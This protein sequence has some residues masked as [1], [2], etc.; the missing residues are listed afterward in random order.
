[1]K[2]IF[3]LSVL[4]YFGVSNLIFSQEDS[5]DGMIQTKTQKEEEKRGF[6]KNYLE[7]QFYIGL[8]YNYLISDATKVVQHNFSRG[9]HTGFLRDIPM[10][11]RRNIGMALGLGYSYDLI[12]S[13]I[14]SLS[15]NRIIEYHIANNL[16][17]WN[18]NKNYF[19]T[20]TIELPIEF[21]WRTSTDKSHKFWRVYTGVKLGY[22]FSARSL[23]KQNELTAYF[24]N[25]DIANQW[26]LKVF[27][28]FGY[29]TWNFFVQ[30]N[31]S[32]I[33]KNAKTTDNISLKSSL[34]QLGLNFYIL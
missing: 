24:S 1:M 25:S 8:T 6:G 2:R 28:V 13:N 32:P 23:T 21:R 3:Y 4:L 9:I 20:H 30:Y 27:S 33:L 19:E 31:L 14:I 16:N 22:V 26:H 15:K 7:D 29:N 11:Q 17:D 18:L 5:D 12:Y 10:N 34:L